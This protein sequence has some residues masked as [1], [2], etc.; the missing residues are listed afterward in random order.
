MKKFDV[1]KWN[2]KRRLKETASK[3]G[4]LK[5][6]YNMD[7]MRYHGGDRDKAA[8]DS[9]E[10]AMGQVN[11]DISK[12]FWDNNEQQE[13]ELQVTSADGT[14]A[15]ITDP[16]DIRDF[17]TG[18]GIIYGED[19]D[20]GSVEV[21]LDNAQDHQMAEGSCGYGPDGVPGDTPGE[22]QGANA[23]DR[24]RGMLRKLIQK[25][26]A[27][28][29]E[30]DPFQDLYDKQNPNDPKAIKGKHYP[31]EETVKKLKKGPYNK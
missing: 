16:R 10:K 30:S 26:I 14:V 17:L 21:S 3:L 4:Y 8:T 23:D 28:L 2:Q 24:T 18:K 29:N 9:Y 15:M 5:E 13:R 31:D 22:T 1:H 11:N 20:G 27:K 6:E 12:N 25:E 19:Q 7:L